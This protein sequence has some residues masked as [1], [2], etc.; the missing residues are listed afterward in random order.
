VHLRL[1]R[2]LQKTVEAVEDQRVHAQNPGLSPAPEDRTPG[3][4][5]VPTVWRGLRIELSQTSLP[6]KRMTGSRP[7][8]GRVRK[9]LGSDDAKPF[10]SHGEIALP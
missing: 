10:W 4:P 5:S 8:S 1:D 7:T 9:R 3:T 2:A 6:R